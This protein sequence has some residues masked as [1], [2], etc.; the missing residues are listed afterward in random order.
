MLDQQW[1]GITVAAEVHSVINFSND[2]NDG[3][4]SS[5]GDTCVT[6]VLVE[7]CNIHELYCDPE[8]MVAGGWEF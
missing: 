5:S 3:F 8:K 7:I 4:Y 1:P 2:F 6:R